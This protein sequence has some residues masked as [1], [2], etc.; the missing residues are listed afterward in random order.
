[1]LGAI[2]HGHQTENHRIDTTVRWLR[3]SLATWAQIVEATDDLKGPLWTNGDY[4]HHGINDKV[5]EALAKD[6]K[7]SLVLIKPTKLALVVGKESMF[8]GG[9]QRRVRADF[10][11]NETRYNFVVTDPWVEEKYFAGKDGRFTIAESRLCVSLA[12]VIHGS[13]TK[14]VAT[15]ITPD[16]F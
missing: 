7:N 15:V 16:R 1:M 4:S 8:G 3:K 11:F 12:E 2:P 9:E 5:S 10:N 13:A 14:L 6:L